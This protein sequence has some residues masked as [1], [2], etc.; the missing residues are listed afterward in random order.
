[1]ATQNDV[2]EKIPGTV[3]A[4]PIDARQPGLKRFSPKLIL[5]HVRVLGLSA[6]LAIIGSLLFYKGVI[7]K[8]SAPVSPGPPAITATSQNNDSPV[9]KE[10]KDKPKSKKTSSKSS[11]VQPIPA[12][13]PLPPSG[14]GGGYAMNVL[15]LKYFPLTSNKN[16]INKSVTGDVGDSYA[17][18]R[19][20][21][22]NITK[23]LIADI[24]KA[25]KYLGYKNAS[26]PASLSYKVVAT[27]EHKKAVP[28]KASHGI[29]TYP[30]YSKV[31]TDNSIC[32]YVNNKHVNEVWIWAYQGP[33]K[34]NGYPSLAISESKM[35][36]AYGDI[37]NSWRFD[38]MPRCSHTYVVYTYNYGRGTAEA[39][40]SWSHQIESEV[41]AVDSSLFNLFQGNSHP[42]ASHVNGRC[43][44][45]HNP[46]NSRFEYDYA[47]TKAQK[48]DCLDWR[49]GG[50]GKLTSISCK[51][52]GCN[53]ISDNN[54][55]QLN[56]LMWMWQNMPGKNNT[57]TYQGKHLRNWW[58]IHGKF[59]SVMGSSKTLLK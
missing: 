55:S 13:S 31:L 3:G 43:G 8:N 4:D 11:S 45:V 20:R 48:S 9:S 42:Q 32:S 51:T 57:K 50:G 2:S 7:Q 14:N 17:A 24:P 52:W 30:N 18:V 49:P 36:G 47:N 5:S 19:Q 33:D 44:S 40:H 58:D 59:D 41:K 46:P 23:N 25:T 37:S 12:P 54:N 22:I 1:V 29:P 38:D 10:K 6:T 35:S 21:T 53:Y 26:A 56:W 27:K 34:S 28:I 39:F 16:N 15:V